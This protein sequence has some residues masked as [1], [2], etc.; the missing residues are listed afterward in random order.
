MNRLGII[1][2]ANKSGGLGANLSDIIKF[3]RLSPI[4][5]CRVLRQRYLQ[6][7]IQFSGS[8]SLYGLSVNIVYHPKD[9][10][11]PLTGQR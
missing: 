6:D 7:P 3:N 10:D 9:F 2:K 11:P 4:K 5:R 1:H 8:D